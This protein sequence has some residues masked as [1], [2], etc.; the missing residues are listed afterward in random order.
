MFVVGVV[1]CQAYHAKIMPEL[2][3]KPLDS[4]LGFWVIKGA[5]ALLAM[6][7]ECEAVVHTVKVE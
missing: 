6:T 4:F 3:P 2:F 1:A 5:G 7:C